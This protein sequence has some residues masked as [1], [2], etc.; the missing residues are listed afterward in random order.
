MHFLKT[1]L[2][3]TIAMGG[4][5]GFGAV[6]AANVV[7]LATGAT[8][9]QLYHSSDPVSYGQNTIEIN[10]TKLQNSGPDYVSSNI[11][12]KPGQTIQYSAQKWDI[13][14]YD[15]TVPD[16]PPS[17]NSC[18]QLNVIPGQWI[19][20]EGDKGCIPSSGPSTNVC[21]PAGSQASKV[22]AGHTMEVKLRWAKCS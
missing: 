9:Y 13:N 1:T 17:N 3:S 15:I 7:A 21:I 8:N 2:I 4:L 11:N 20:G 10:G 6:H 19:S 14:K 22:N 5:I 12:V 16:L 18:E